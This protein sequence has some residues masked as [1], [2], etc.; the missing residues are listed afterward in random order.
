[1]HETSWPLEQIQEHERLSKLPEPVNVA[2]HP[3]STGQPVQVAFLPVVV[4]KISHVDMTEV[5]SAVAVYVKH[6]NA[7]KKIGYV[8][9]DAMLCL[10]YRN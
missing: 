4:L 5:S 10:K 7:N 9:L 1:M 6:A 8:R 2:V 3:L